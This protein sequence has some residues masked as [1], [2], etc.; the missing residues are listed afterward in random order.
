MLNAIE[1]LGSRVLMMIAQVG[2]TGIATATHVHY[3]VW[4]GGRPQNPLNY[5]ISG[6]IP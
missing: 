4:V 2:R 1:N 3:E 5:V 6:A